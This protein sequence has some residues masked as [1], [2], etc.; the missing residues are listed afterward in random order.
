[1]KRNLL[2]FATLIAGSSLLVTSCTDE[3]GTGATV[4][5]I[6]ID[7]IETNNASIQAGQ[8]FE[9][10]INA[11]KNSADITE[12]T[13]LENGATLPATAFTVN[14]SAPSNN[15][16]GI[17]GSDADEF[18][19]TYVITTP[20]STEGE[21]EYEVVVKDADGNDASAT[22]LITTTLLTDIGLSTGKLSNMSGPAG[23][24]GLD[25]DSGLP[26]GSA[27]LKNEIADT[28]IDSSA[29]NFKVNWKKIIK[30]VNGSELR[31]V[32]S[33]SV[34]FDNIKTKAQ[35]ETAF[36]NGSGL[37]IS[38]VVKVGD[39][40]AV[41]RAGTYYLIR[42]KEVVNVDGTSVTDPNRNTDY[43]IFEIKH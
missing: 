13:I 40:F 11:Q 32:S 4:K 9:L 29:T 27:D 30:P 17:T 31:K 37:L 19:Q 15:P 3:S 20:G 5:I 25:L 12:V 28:G 18:T 35:I 8:S 16:F 26:Y 24:G 6:T 22:A 34:N 38:E 2:L 33:V 7:G 14:G 23:V 42:A 43:I 36:D 39:T 10:V 1:M 21:I 41:L